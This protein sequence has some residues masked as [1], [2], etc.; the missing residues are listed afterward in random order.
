MGEMAPY[1]LLFMPTVKIMSKLITRATQIVNIDLELNPYEFKNNPMIHERRVKLQHELNGLKLNPALIKRLGS[2]I[3]EVDTSL[4]SE[5]VLKI[6][7]A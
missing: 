2:E 7:N 5:D 6:D 3:Y 1:T 4:L